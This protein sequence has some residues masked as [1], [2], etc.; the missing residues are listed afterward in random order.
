MS[1]GPGAAPSGG[2]P[3]VEADEWRAALDRR[4]Y[5]DLAVQKAELVRQFPIF[6]AL[7]DAA[8]RRLSRALATRCGS[9][10]ATA[11]G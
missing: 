4:P 8:R 5:L 10:P 7:D 2:A 6:A 1:D 9:P 3:A 11:P